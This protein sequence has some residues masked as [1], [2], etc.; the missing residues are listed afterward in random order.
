MS[1]KREG[2]FLCHSAFQPSSVF[3]L[4]FGKICF[5]ICPT[6][7][8]I[9]QADN[10][11]VM[12]LKST[13]RISQSWLVCRRRLLWGRKYLS[14]VIEALC[15]SEAGKRDPIVFKHV[16]KKS[17]SQLLLLVQHVKAGF[18]E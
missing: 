7:P 14:V 11:L 10:T 18:I 3:I 6:T 4:S 5:I 9:P 17:F 13:R 12:N 2:G 15:C 8:N 16:L 1:V